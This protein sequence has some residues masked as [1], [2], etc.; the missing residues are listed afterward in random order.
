MPGAS[1][2]R[3]AEALT[4]ANGAMIFRAADPMSPSAFSCRARYLCSS[5]SQ[6]ETGAAAQDNAAPSR[7]QRRARAGQLHTHASKN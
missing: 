1:Q 7:L 4:L 5:A 2:G 3:K 6:D